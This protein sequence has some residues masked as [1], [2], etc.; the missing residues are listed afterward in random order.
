MCLTT[1]LCLGLR[2]R[3]S[4]RQQRRQV[5]F[6]TVLSPPTLVTYEAWN[7]KIS[8][9]SMVRN[10]TPPLCGNKVWN[11]LRLLCPGTELQGMGPS[12]RAA[13]LTELRRLR[14][15]RRLHQAP[16]RRP[17]PRR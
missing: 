9:G 13:M 10:L 15:R 16:L 2:L 12:E 4:Q 5:L 6:R 11:R 1:W 8:T 7:L 3:A 14:P 17:P